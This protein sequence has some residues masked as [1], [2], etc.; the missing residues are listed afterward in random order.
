MGK[1]SALINKTTTNAAHAVTRALPLE[2]ARRSTRSHTC[3]SNSK[4]A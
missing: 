1:Q 2:Q 3:N 4:R